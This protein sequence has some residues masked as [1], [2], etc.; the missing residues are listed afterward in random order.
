M[1]KLVGRWI[2]IVLALLAAAWFVPGFH[3]GGDAW[4][5]YAVMAAVL[6]VVNAFVRPVL[7]LLTCPLILLTLGLFTLVINAAMLLLAARIAAELGVDF[8]ID[9]F[10]PAFWG[11]LIVSV[12]T[13]VLSVFVKDKD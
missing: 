11:G 8:R 10:W 4:V 7:K 3:V 1:S 6:G 5:A 9:G 2:I 13:T 12:V